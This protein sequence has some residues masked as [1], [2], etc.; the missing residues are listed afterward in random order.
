MCLPNELDGCA[1]NFYKFNIECFEH[2]FPLCDYSETI[3][4]L[5]SIYDAMAS[6]DE[7]DYSSKRVIITVGDEAPGKPSVEINDSIFDLQA[8][9]IL[10]A[11]EQ[12]ARPSSYEA[13]RYMRNE[14][15]SSFW[16]QE[17]NHNVVTQCVQ[18][19][20]IFNELWKYSTEDCYF[21][22]RVSVYVR[23]EWGS[24]RK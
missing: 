8:I 16:K 10:R 2:L 14:R 9:C 22:S 21:Y 18:G 5:S 4:V 23:R 17:R 7:L 19:E 1:A 15:Y 20:H 11:H 12:G 3:A 6:S 13:V 24:I